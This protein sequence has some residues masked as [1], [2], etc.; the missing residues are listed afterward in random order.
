MMGNPV[1]LL[2]QRGYCE[3]GVDI[4]IPKLPGDELPPKQRG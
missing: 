3:G 1:R 4:V 2:K